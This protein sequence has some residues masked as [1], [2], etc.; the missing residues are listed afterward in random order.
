MSL[1]LTIE[2]KD[3]TNV[4]G[5]DAA[6]AQPLTLHQYIADACTAITRL[7]FAE[8]GNRPNK[9]NWRPTGFWMRMASGTVAIATAVG[10]MPRPATASSTQ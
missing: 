7:L 9:Q 2:A 5:L 1:T 3:Y 6:L 8:L 10:M 4:R